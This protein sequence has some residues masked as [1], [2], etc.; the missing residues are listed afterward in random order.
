MLILKV[1]DQYGGIHQILGEGYSGLNLIG[2]P[3]AFRQ[4]SN[5]VDAPQCFLEIAFMHENSN[6]KFSPKVEKKCVLADP[7]SFCNDRSTAS[8]L[9]FGAFSFFFF[10][11]LT[12]GAI[13]RIR[14][15]RAGYFLSQ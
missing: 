4:R 10:W 2:K 15:S 12:H 9:A 6:R 3:L 14:S 7:D 13:L 11:G 5:A 8:E 1:K